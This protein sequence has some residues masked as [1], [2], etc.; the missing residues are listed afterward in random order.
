MLQKITT[1]VNIDLRRPGVPPTLYAKQDDSGTRAVHIDFFDGGQKYIAPASATIVIRY[2]AASGACGAYDTID[3][4]SAYAWDSDYSGVTID[5]AGAMLA[6]QGVVAV[7]ASIV[8]GNQQISTFSINVIVERSAAAG[9]P[10]EDYFGYA[11][12]NELASIV[13][14]LR[15]DT[16]KIVDDV[17]DLRADVS[18]Q[19]TAL[20]DVASKVDTNATY[21]TE[22]QEADN[23]TNAR[24]SGLEANPALEVDLSAD[25]AASGGD[26]AVEYLVSVAQAHSNS[27]LLRVSEGDYTTTA[28]CI[29]N[30]A[31]GDG[32]QY[33]EITQY[34]DEG[35]IER[36]VLHNGIR[37]SLVVYHGRAD[38]GK[39]PVIDVPSAAKALDVIPAK[40]DDLGNRVSLLEGLKPLTSWADVQK[41]VRAGLAS[42]YFAI[43]DQLQCKRGD[44]VL[45]WDVIGIDH[46]TPAD[47]KYK[48]SLTLQLHDCMEDKYPF[49]AAEP[50]N[51]DADR[52]LYGSNNWSESGIRQ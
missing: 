13:D 17:D 51:P 52:K 41:I 47:P 48:H 39:L 31:I 44:K 10:A 6:E 9:T 18:E 26:D 42:R 11:A 49:D 8:D 5:L 15:S 50:T 25:F 24:V 43:G 33:V 12:L 28:R 46:D 34:T 7:D 40:V 37:L 23:A 2:A 35:S 36:S 29:R 38:G 14:T 3:G 45:T 32:A 16:Q 1:D 4:A 30:D 19:S 20:Q 27:A 22:L 21:I